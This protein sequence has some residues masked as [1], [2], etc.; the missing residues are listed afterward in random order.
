VQV[1]EWGAYFKRY[2]GKQ[3]QEAYLLGLG[4]SMQDGDGLYN[5]VSSK[6]R[7]L[8]YKNERIDQLF[9]L[10]RATMDRA[11]RRKI[12]SDLAR[13]M[14]EDATW[15]FLLQ[16]GDIYAM[17]DRLAWTP[18]PDQWMLFPEATLKEK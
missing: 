3:F 6:G 5:L 2:L 16:Q 18:R 4:G 10:G 12:Y 13:A 7:G 17:R 11:A 9:D 8:Y 1:A 14:I 15:V